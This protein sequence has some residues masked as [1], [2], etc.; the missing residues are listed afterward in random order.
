V[1]CVQTRHQEST[2]R[3]S[4]RHAL[5]HHWPSK[6]YRKRGHQC[7]HVGLVAFA[8][9]SLN[10]SRRPFF[11]MPRDFSSQCWVVASWIVEPV[12]GGLFQCKK[13]FRLLGTRD[14]CSCMSSLSM[15]LSH[16]AGLYGVR[17][18]GPNRWCERVA[19]GFYLVFPTPSYDR[20]SLLSFAPLTL[21]AYSKA[22]CKAYAV[23][24]GIHYSPLWLLTLRHYGQACLPVQSPPA[25]EASVP[26]SWHA[27]IQMVELSGWPNR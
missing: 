1:T 13:F 27:M 26:A 3:A 25:Y 16:A 19:S 4:W 14:Q 21:P 9:R 7:R 24:G 11:Q 15:Q 5:C 18:L 2:R 20:C 22:W 17:G 6:T 8:F 23:S 10:S 12:C